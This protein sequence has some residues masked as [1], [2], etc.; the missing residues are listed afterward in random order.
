MRTPFLLCALLWAVPLTEAE[1]VTPWQDIHRVPIPAQLPPHPRVFCTQADLRRVRAELKRG[2]PYA[3]AC[4]G[5]IVSRADLAMVSDAPVITGQPSRALL[6]Q[7]AVLAQAYALTGDSRYA[8]KA[9]GVLLAVS[10]VVMTLKRTRS[11]GLMASRTLTEGPLAVNFAMAYD[12]TANAPVF[13]AD[14]RNTVCAALRR[15]GWEA[16]HH[17]HHRDSSNWRSWALC[18]LASC[19]FASGDRELIEEAINGVWDPKR[20]CYLYGAVQQL[21]HS[22]F[23]DGVHWERCMGYTYY[24]GSALMYVLVAAKNSGIDLWQAQLPGILGPFVG[25]APHEEYGPAGTRSFKA[26]LDAPFYYAFPGGGFARVGDS[27][28]RAIAYHPMYEIAWREYGDPKYAWLIRRDRDTRGSEAP[29]FWQL[30]IARGKPE[31]AVGKAASAPGSSALRLRTGTAD[32]IAAVQDVICPGDQALVVTGRVK[33]LTFSGGKA[34]IRCNVGKKAFFSETP[35]QAGDWQGVSVTVPAGSDPEVRR[36]RLHVF[37]EGGAG[38]VLWDDV[39]AQVGGEGLSLVRNGA[40]SGGRTDGRR[41]D[42]WGLINGVGD[43]PAGRYDLA[44]DDTIGVSGRNTNG[45]SLFPVGGFAILRADPGDPEALAVNLA[46]GPYGSGHDHPDRLT[47]TVHALGQVIC[48]DAGSWGYENPMHLTWANQTVAHN[49]VSIDGLSQEPQGRSRSIWAGERGE[50]R[51]FGVLRLFHAGDHLKAARATCDTAYEG[52]RLDRTVC[53]AGGYLL[54]VYRV[55]ATTGRTIDLPLHGYGEATVHVGVNA[56]GAPP[57]AGLGY[58]HLGAVQRMSSG[59]STVGLTF[60]D[61]ERQLRVIQSLP[62]GGEAFLA[63]DPTRGNQATSCLLAR[64]RGRNATFVTLLAPSRDAEAHHG[65]V[66]H[67]R[68]GEIVAEIAHVEGTDRLTL[69]NA[70]DGGIVLERRGKNG[71]LTLRESAGAVHE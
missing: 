71:S 67:E 54:D 27:G 23:S 64:R 4:R 22:I 33:V 50:Q 66:V 49:T 29:A 59:S 61:G 56:S 2:V 37:L 28:T 12:L 52:G 24:T 36:V 70:L 51:V 30:W 69:V 35:E 19:G 42:F 6:E 8:T 68:G 17:C 62:K 25:S 65:L 20:E 14:D 31:W 38:E 32:R 60:R 9:H 57:F 34:H 46:Y 11:A 10:R 3:L 55:S 7:A 13:T 5:D 15:V 44:D 58:S 48:P 39:C 16:G 45:C 41:A 40:F 26:F 43:V 53:L 1:G 18:V 47:I 21:A 63:R